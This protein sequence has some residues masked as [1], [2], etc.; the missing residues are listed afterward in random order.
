MKS[1]SSLS[2]SIFRK[3]TMSLI[4]FGIL[5]ACNSLQAQSIGLNFTGT[6]IAESGFR[7]PDSMGTVGSDHIVEMINGRYAV[8]DKTSGTQLS[9]VSLNA[10]W[11]D[12]GSPHAGAF[13][14]DPRVQY[15]P[16]VGR[17]YATSVDN[18]GGENNF[19]FAVSDSGNP[20]D[21]WSGFS[22]DADTDNMQWADFP[23]MGF[24]ADS[25]VISNNMFGLNGGGFEINMLVIPKADVVGATPTLANA[26]LLED[27]FTATGGGFSLQAAIDLDNS[28][29]PIR[30]FSNSS[31]PAGQLTAIQIDGGPNNPVV[32]DIADV[33]GLTAYNTPPLADQPGEGTNL[34]SGG[35]RTR[36]AL[37]LINGSYYGVHNVE[38]P[39][40]GNAALQWYQLDADTLAVINE[41][42]IADADLDLIYGSIAANE[43]GDIVIGATG[44]SETVFASA[45]AVVGDTNEMGDVEFGELLLLQSGVA[46]YELLSSGRN[47]WGDYSATVLDP[48]DHTRFWTFQE[49]VSGE[50]QWSIQISEIRINAVPEPSGCVAIGLLATAMIST[51]RR[52][53]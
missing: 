46:E 20:L 50:N 32:N 44:S 5:A 4:C 8:Y 48:D 17:Y 24:S 37:T 33:T 25:I 2:Y 42:L 52:R 11:N 43:F 10:F 18:A 26:T 39:T 51:R 14:F 34:D 45:F 13:A 21:G 47:R 53:I 1:Q 7:P 49:F 22:V 23:Q 40:S 29:R 6:S 9:S 16:S 30:M 28:S 12:A 15:D 27:Q 31:A 36:S 35:G 19:L 3:F 41:G 38:D